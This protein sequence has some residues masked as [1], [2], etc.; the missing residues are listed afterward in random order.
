MITEKLT[1]RETESRRRLWKEAFGDSDAFLD[2]FDRTAFSPERYCA[3]IIGSEV[4]S[5]LYYFDC[6][7][8][9]GRLAYIYAVATAKD[10]RGQGLCR[11]LLDEAHAYLAEQGYTGAILCP[12]SDS[13]FGFYE[14]MGY[15]TCTY[16]SECE[17]TA[18]DAV[19]VREITKDEYAR[20]RRKYL[21][22]GGIV[23]ER[24]NIDFLE[25]FSKFYSGDGFVL[26]A[27]PDGDRLFCAEILGDTD[28]AAGIARAL[29]FERGFFRTVGNDKPFTMYYPLDKK[30]PP[31][32]YFG[33]AFD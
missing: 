22:E 3:I 29:G 30:A 8:E 16:V 11:K 20:L 28:A 12:G 14:S 27:R 17:V 6:E 7:Y 9:G 32:T 19:N 13:L 15:K 1:E 2:D 26:T 33:L 24:E 18:G 23:Q 5:A 4:V 21:P 25:T 10:Y 31:P